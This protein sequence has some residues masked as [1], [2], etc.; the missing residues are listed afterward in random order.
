MS[1][2][3]IEELLNE[4]AG[5]TE[6]FS[7][8][9][10]EIEEL[11]EPLHARMGLSPELLSLALAETMSGKDVEPLNQQ[12]KPKKEETIVAAFDAPA[13]SGRTLLIFQTQDGALWQLC[14]AGLG[15][16]HHDAVDPAWPAAKNFAGLLPAK[17]NP[18]PPVTAPWTWPPSLGVQLGEARR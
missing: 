12:R 13:A 5:D 16:T 7:R 17:I 10:A 6:L 18:R 1:V 15:C 2:S 3:G 11:M 4:L 14:D 9:D 8:V